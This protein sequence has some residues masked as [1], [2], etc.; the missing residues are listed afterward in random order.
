[1]MDNKTLPDPG[2]QAQIKE[3]RKPFEAF[4]AQKV[5]DS[6][7]ELDQTTCQQRECLL[8]DFMADA[9][10]EYRFNSSDA[11]VK[12]DFALINAGGIRATIDVGE[13]TRGEVLTSFPFGNSIVELTYKGDKLRMIL[14]GCVSRLNQFNNRPL[15]SWFQVSKNIRIQYNPAN[16]NGTKLVN[17]QIGGQPIDPAKDYRVVTLDFLAGGGDNIFEPT[18]NFISLDTQDEVLVKYIVAKSPVNIALDGRIQAVNGTASTPTPTG[19]GTTPT[20]TP[21]GAGVAVSAPILGCLLALGA[22]AF[23]V[24]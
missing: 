23:F 12:P 17:V 24:I 21:T 8:G 16:A 9:M 15:T 10:Y 4:S 11:V 13:I 14:E 18:T 19:N 6:Q 2:L 3:W 1:M 22:V 20:P 5:G 7:V